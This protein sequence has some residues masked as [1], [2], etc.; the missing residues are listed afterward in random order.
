MPADPPPAPPLPPQRQQARNAFTRF[1]QQSFTSYGSR[2]PS[3]AQA[4][5]DS[6][7]PPLQPRIPGCVV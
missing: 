2:P 6:A 5:P 7:R 3:A 4:R 1:V